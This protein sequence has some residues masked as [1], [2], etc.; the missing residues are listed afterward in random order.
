MGLHMGGHIYRGDYTWRIADYNYKIMTNACCLKT[1]R[2]SFRVKHC[3]KLCM[4]ECSSG[5]CIEST[6]VWIEQNVM[7]LHLLV[8]LILLALKFLK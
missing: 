8:F 6:K 7:V 5:W 3:L 1:F 4:K 2:L